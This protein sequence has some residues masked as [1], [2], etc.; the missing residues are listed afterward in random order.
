MKKTSVVIVLVIILAVLVMGI[1]EKTLSATVGNMGTIIMYSII[2][3]ILAVLYVRASRQ[4]KAEE[5]KMRKEHP[6]LFENEI[7]D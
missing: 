1:M 7:E 4:A 3:V 6:E 2:A 5:E